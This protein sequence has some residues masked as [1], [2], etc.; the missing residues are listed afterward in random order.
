[1]GHRTSVTDP[2]RGTWNY[3]YNG[4]GELKRQLDARGLTLNQSF[5]NL[6]R[7]TARSWQQPGRVTPSSTTPFSDSFVYNNTPG[8]QYG[9]LT[10]SSRTGEGTISESYQYDALNRPIAKT[11]SGTNVASQN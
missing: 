3:Q 9:T 2:N 4:F 10:S 8:G 11:Y 7:M 5:D 1:M 6:G